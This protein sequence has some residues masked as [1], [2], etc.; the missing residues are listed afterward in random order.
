MVWHSLACLSESKGW[1]RYLMGSDE[2]VVNE[3]TA[4]FYMHHTDKK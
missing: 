2:R 4:L 1:A 3:D